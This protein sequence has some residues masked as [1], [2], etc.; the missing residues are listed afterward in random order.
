MKKRKVF[1]MAYARANVGD[2]LFIVTLLEKYKDIDFYIGIKEMSFAKAFK[3]YKNITVIQNEEENFD[4]R[5]PEEYDAYIYV[6]GSIFMEG[7]KV[8]NL[9]N[10]CNEF[11]K[12]CYN[13]KIPF[14]YV[15]SNFGPYQTQ[16]YFDLAK[17]T[18]KYCKDI[19]F[20]DMYSYNLFQDIPTVRYAPD[21]MFNLENIEDNIQKNTLGISIIDM[22]IRNSLQKYENAYLKCMINN[23]IR[24]IEQ[25]KTVYLFSFCKEEND[26]KAIEY[27]ESQIPE[28]YKYRIK[29]VYYD[30][31]IK[32]FIRIYK[33]MEYMICCRFHAMI[34]STAFG[35][36]MYI[37]SYSKKIDNVIQDLELTEKYTQIEDL[38]E[39]TVIKLNDF[40]QVD[41]EKINKIK[42]K[43]K[44]QL[45][46]IDEWY[47]QIE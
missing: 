26:E 10:K 9:D 44:D 35:Q 42:D 23:I 18:F 20:R 3:E 22:S 15:S 8:Y 16:E 37:L 6:G 5:I 38:E 41:K 46:K 13:K 39:N 1:I 4:N 17:D 24:Y 28:Q 36:K 47:L 27:I 43:S 7:G 40:K 31:D 45:L 29:K 33:S 19:C 25:E 21:L 11:M 2:D 34:I 14:F 12:K 32:Q 30:G